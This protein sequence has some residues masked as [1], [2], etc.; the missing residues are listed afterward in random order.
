MAGFVPTP[1]PTGPAA[2]TYVVWRKATRGRAALA[3]VLVFG[4]I[5]FAWFEGAL[6]FAD[7]H[8]TLSGPLYAHVDLVGALSHLLGIFALI[9]VIIANIRAVR[10]VRTG[11]PITPA[12]QAARVGRHVAAV[13]TLLPVIAMIGMLMGRPRGQAV[14]YLV[15][16]LG[17][18]IGEAVFSWLLAA[19][20]VKGLRS[21]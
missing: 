2:P 19:W 1:V 5:G 10:A 8:D 4:N 3:V 15:M 11:Q 12:Q 18:A 16:F 9:P 21:T 17:F 6:W 7:R 13:R 14:V 20:T